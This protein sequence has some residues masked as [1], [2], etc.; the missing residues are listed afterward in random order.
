MANHIQPAK[1]MSL[2]LNTKGQDSESIQRL[3]RGILN[4]VGCP[5]CGRLGILRVDI[6]SDP[7]PEFAKEGVI[8][9]HEQGF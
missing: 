3:I 2:T 8:G 4:R 6:L 1:F 5:N 9:L 7:G